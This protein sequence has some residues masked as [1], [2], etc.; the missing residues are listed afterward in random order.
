MYGETHL[1]SVQL[2][3]MTF[4]GEYN[5]VWRPLFDKLEEW[6]EVNDVELEATKPVSQGPG[7]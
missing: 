6:I 1:K 5:D 4:Q 3:M 2:C 7:G